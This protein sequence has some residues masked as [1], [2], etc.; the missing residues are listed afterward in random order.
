[1]RTTQEAFDEQTKDLQRAVK[2]SQ[3]EFDKEK[4]LLE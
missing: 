2:K 3:S 1:M 4:A